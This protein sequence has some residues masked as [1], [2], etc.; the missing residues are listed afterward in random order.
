MTVK[1]EMKSGAAEKQVPT[2]KPGINRAFVL[3][4]A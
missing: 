1:E 2:Q 4:N 3:V